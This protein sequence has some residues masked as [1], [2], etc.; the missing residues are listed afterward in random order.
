MDAYALDYYSS[1]T[2]TSHSLSVLL[3]LLSVKFPSFPRIPPSPLHWPALASAVVTGE[4]IDRTDAV[5]SSIARQFPLL[6]Q[7]TGTGSR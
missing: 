1:F 3:L 2:A 5:H 6:L 7:I 4:E